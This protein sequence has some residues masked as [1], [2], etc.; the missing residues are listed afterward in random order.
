MKLDTDEMNTDVAFSLM[1]DH[2]K[3]IYLKT[4]DTPEFQK[5]FKAWK[6]RKEGR[7]E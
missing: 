5:G 7:N 1:C 4:R 2:F 3:E 6:A